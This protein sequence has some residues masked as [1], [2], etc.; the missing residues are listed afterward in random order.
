MPYI[1]TVTEEAGLVASPNV[2]IEPPGDDIVVQVPMLPVTDR[3]APR[4]YINPHT[5]SSPPAAA[6]GCSVFVK[7]TSSKLS[8]HVPFEF[9]HLSVALVPTGTPVIEAVGEFS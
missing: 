5:W 6:T 1:S 2:I 4:L 3:T 7:T 8:V 9:V